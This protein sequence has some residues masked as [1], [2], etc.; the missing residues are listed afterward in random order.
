MLVDGMGVDFVARP[1]ADAR[2]THLALPI[3]TVGRE[4]PL[5]L[6]RWVFHIPQLLDQSFT[7]YYQRMVFSKAQAGKYFSYSNMA[8]VWLGSL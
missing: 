7:S 8:P 3:I 6:T 5:S 2:Y 1:K 4:I